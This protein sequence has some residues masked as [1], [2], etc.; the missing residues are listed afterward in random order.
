[1]IEQTYVNYNRSFILE[2]K[3]ACNQLTHRSKFY[4]C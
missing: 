1:M 3:I 2:I 4:D